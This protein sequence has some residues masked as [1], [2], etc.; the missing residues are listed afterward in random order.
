MTVHT[1]IKELSCHLC[2]KVRL[3]K[4]LRLSLL[5]IYIFIS[6]VWNE[7]RAKHAH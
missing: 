2:F 1:G 6:D 3:L 4:R 7:E 5:D